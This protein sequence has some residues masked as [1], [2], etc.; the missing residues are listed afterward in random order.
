MGKLEEQATSLYKEFADNSSTVQLLNDT[1]ANVWTGKLVETCMSLGIPYGS[2]RKVIKA[3][4]D[5]GAIEVSSGNRGTPTVVTLLSEPTPEMLAD[6][7]LRRPLTDALQA[8][9]ILSDAR[10]VL[11]ELGGINIGKALMNME[12][13]LQVIEKKLGEMNGKTKGR[14]SNTSK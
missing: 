12:S 6:E 2:Y 10:Q 8:A 13:R 5:V 1:T 14:T 11:D 3:L 4:I 9:K 7:S